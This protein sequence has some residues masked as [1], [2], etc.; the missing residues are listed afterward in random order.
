MEVFF[1]LIGIYAAEVG[2]GLCKTDWIIRFTFVPFFFFFLL[3]IK[4][5]KRTLFRGVSGHLPW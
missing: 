5:I 3:C 2:I 1:F 4:V